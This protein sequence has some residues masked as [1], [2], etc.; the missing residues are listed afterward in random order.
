MSKTYSSKNGRACQN[1]LGGRRA[2]LSDRESIYR[3]PS[4]ANEAGRRK[5][6]VTIVV[7]G[8]ARSNT[9]SDGMFFTALS[10][11]LRIT[12][13]DLLH[14]NTLSQHWTG[15]F[16]SCGSLRRANASHALDHTAKRSA[17]RSMPH[18]TGGRGVGVDAFRGIFTSTFHRSPW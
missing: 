14:G 17:A 2:A 1:G 5:E 9:Y 12:R 6:Q 15:W 11:N 10:P 18:G 7:Q 4:S 13:N 3:G 16:T 8:G